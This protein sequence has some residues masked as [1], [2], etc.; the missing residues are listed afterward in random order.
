MPTDGTPEPGGS[1]APSDALAK[2]MAELRAEHAPA[3]GERADRYW[4]RLGIWLGLHQPGRAALLL[5]GL[6]SGTNVLSPAQA[7][8]P[9][10]R[11]ASD[12]TDEAN[13]TTTA[14]PIAAEAPDADPIAAEAPD[15]DPIAAEAPDADPIAAEAPD[16]DPADPADA[17][18]PADPDEVPVCS[19]LLAR[20]S[21][22]PPSAD[23]ETVFG[24]VGRL[25]PNEIRRLGHA[26]T[27]LLAG[28]ATRDLERGFGLAWSA[29]TRLPREDLRRLFGRFSELELAVC[30]VLGSRDLL[31]IAH[32]AESNVG[33]LLS[34]FTKR[35][36]PAVTEATAILEREGEPARRGLVAIWNAWVAMRYRDLIAPPLFEQLVEPWVTVVGRLP[37]P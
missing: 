31:S 37:Q 27:E 32:P 11:A 12:T 29:G 6:E 28:G 3:A 2:A 24:W 35:S 1:P 18:D 5:G 26:V 9:S 15:A 20:T 14:D 16:A 13:T 22:L 17:A 25:S 8:E 30:G 34:I 4:L 19:R 10:Q 23:P 7:P 33:A 36:N 21:G